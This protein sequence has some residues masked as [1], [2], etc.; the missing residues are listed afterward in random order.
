MLKVFRFQKFWPFFGQ[1]F[2]LGGLEMS[3]ARD[4]FHGASVATIYVKVIKIAVEEGVF[5][6]IWW[7]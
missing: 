6:F 3:S 4:V 7:A 2:D 5:S 1:F